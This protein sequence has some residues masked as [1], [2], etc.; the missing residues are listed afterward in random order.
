[1]PLLRTPPPQHHILRMAAGQQQRETM[2]ESE[3]HNSYY[4]NVGA[5]KRRSRWTT[6]ECLAAN[7]FDS[8]N[9]AICPRATHW[10]YGKRGENVN[11][12]CLLLQQCQTI[13]LS[14]FPKSL[15]RFR[16]RIHTHHRRDAYAT[17]RWYIQFNRRKRNEN[18]RDMTMGKSSAFILSHYDNLIMGIYK[19]YVVSEL[20]SLLT[21]PRNTTAFC[22][23]IGLFFIF[24][25]PFFCFV[26]ASAVEGTLFGR[27]LLLQFKWELHAT[28]KNNKGDTQIFGNHYPLWNTVFTGEYGHIYDSW[29]IG[30]D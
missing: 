6:A 29:T 1:M 21:A 19:Y 18:V 24:A 7:E 8:C 26:C 2:C 9:V 22:I 13:L 17:G 23:I 28:H 4:D 27:G 10:I 11:T 16:T 5:S 14:C 3:S 25:V 30:S 15:I 20:C 12:T